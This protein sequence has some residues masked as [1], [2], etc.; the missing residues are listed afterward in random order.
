MKCSHDQARS[1]TGEA[2]IRVASLL[3]RVPAEYMHDL[4]LDLAW[5]A[6]VA[7]HRPDALHKVI[8]DWEITL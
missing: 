1:R 8:H 4:A 7:A 6:M 5:A 3:D 2:A